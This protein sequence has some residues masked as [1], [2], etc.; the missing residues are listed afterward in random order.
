MKYKGTQNITKEY[1]ERQRNT[2]KQQGKTKEHKGIKKNI[3][4]YTY[5][6]I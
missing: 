4:G 5:E 3:R 2:S 6:G 1:E